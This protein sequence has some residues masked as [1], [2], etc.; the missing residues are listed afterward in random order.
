MKRTAEPYLQAITR[1]LHAMAA[2]FVAITAALAPTATLASGSAAPAHG[3]ATET[4]EA[5]QRMDLLDVGAFRIRFSQPTDGE[6]IDLRFGVCFVLSSKTTADDL[7]QLQQ[8][9]HRLRDQ[10]IIAVRSASAEDYNEPDLRRLQRLIMF[11][12]KRLDAS[13]H[14][15]GAYLTDFSLERGETM[16][17]LMVPAVTPSAAPPKSSGGGH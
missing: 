15:L 11:R 4:P 14:I 13:T 17:D 8:W 1:R 10:V 7:H 6:V 9:T 16:A 2:G 5:P 12:V 3:E